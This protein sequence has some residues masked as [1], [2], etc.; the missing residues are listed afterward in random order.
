M[1]WHKILAHPPKKTQQQL[2]HCFEFLDKIFKIIIKNVYV[3][4]G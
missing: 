2:K 3:C 1:Y 4:F